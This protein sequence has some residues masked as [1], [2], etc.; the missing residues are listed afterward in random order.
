MPDIT[1][2]SDSDAPAIELTGS[3]SFRSGEQNWGSQRRMALLGAIAQ[4]GSISAA[5]RK[6]GLSYKAAWD[7]VDTM[8]N[9]AGEPLV[10]RTTGGKHGGGATLSERAVELLK[11]FE[12]LNR[13][14]QRFLAQLAHSGSLPTHDLELIQHIMMQTS[15][16]NN[17]SGTVAS[18]KHGAVN[19]EVILNI[20]P[21]Q[22]IVASITSESARSLGLEPG[23]RALAFIKASSII[24]GKTDDNVRL[25]ARNQL[26]G[27]I[28]EVKEGAV[29]AEARIELPS[30]QVLVAILT[31][32]SLSRLELKAG[33]PVRAIFKASSVMLGVTD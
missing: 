17:L 25:S 31:M 24:V 16:R 7:A 8:N 28:T 11:L 12:R 19:D 9:L 26:A 2:T 1:P 3:I 4:E 20:A 27:R 18:V 15:A 32:E 5:A 14:H 29:N 6:V 30:G 23:R 10:L 13:E 33:D 21:G 22:D